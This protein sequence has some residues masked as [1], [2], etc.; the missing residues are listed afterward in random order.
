MKFIWICNNTY[1]NPW[2][3]H[4][5]PRQLR[6]TYGLNAIFFKSHNTLNTPFQSTITMV[7]D[8]DEIQQALDKAIDTLEHY[9]DWHCCLSFQGPLTA[10]STLP[11]HA[12]LLALCCHISPLP[13]PDSKKYI[14][15]RNRSWQPTGWSA[16][17]ITIQNTIMCATR[18]SKPPEKKW[19]I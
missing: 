4:M 10:D 5:Q 11:T 16:S 15:I 19:S 8:Y 9:P 12:S 2:F 6:T 14:L 1:A 17:S 18:L 13:N 3:A 7:R